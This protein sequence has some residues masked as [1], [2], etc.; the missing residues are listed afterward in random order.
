MGLL[1][2]SPWTGS[3]TYHNTNGIIW[4][5]RLYWKKWYQICMGLYQNGNGT[6]HFSAK[7]CPKKYKFSSGHSYLH[8]ILIMFP[9]VSDNKTCTK[10]C[11][12]RCYLIVKKWKYCKNGINAHLDFEAENVTTIFYTFSLCRW[13]TCTL[14]KVVHLYVTHI[15]NDVI[16]SHMSG[17]ILLSWSQIFCISLIYDCCFSSHL[18]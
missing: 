17:S 6:R 16:F 13:F 8:S 9:E 4:F 11:L 3:V 5:L 7:N 12:K 1:N 18:L 15:N 14:I 2:V 10:V